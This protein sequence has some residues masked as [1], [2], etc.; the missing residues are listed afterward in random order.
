M[1]KVGFGWLRR[2]RLGGGRFEGVRVCWG[3]V[4]S[5]LPLKHSHRNKN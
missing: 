5:K 1:W 4:G 3:G 2:G